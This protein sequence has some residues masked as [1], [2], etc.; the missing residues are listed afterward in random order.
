MSWAVHIQE[1]LLPAISVGIIYWFILRP[2]IR[3]QPLPWDGFFV[4]AFLTLAWQNYGINWF[5]WV[6]T[7]N[8]VAVN[9]GSWYNYLPL[10]LAPNA[11]SFAENPGVTFGFWAP[12]MVTCIW[13]C[14]WMKVCQRRWPHLG[15][16]GIFVWGLVAAALFD[17]VAENFWLR[18]GTYNYAGAIHG[19]WLLFQGHYYQFPLYEPILFGACWAGTAAVRYFRNDRG[20]SLAERGIEHVH[21]GRRAKGLVRFLALAGILNVLLL[22]YNLTFATLH[23]RYGGTWPRDIQK[24]SYFTQELCG[25]KTDRACPGTGVPIPRPDSAYLTRDGGGVGHPADWKPPGVVPFEK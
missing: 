15:K 24:R 22:T 17:I 10:W 11:Q 9:R 4:G 3:R 23:L 7:Y 16:V 6:S 21:L 13:I 8:A 2:L 25:A 18:T 1:V 14:V 19:P 5:G 20:E 12:W